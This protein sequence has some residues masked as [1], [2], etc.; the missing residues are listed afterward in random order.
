MTKEQEQICLAM[1]LL[2]WEK[3]LLNIVP[4][5]DQ[6][7]HGLLGQWLTLILGVF[8]LQEGRAAGRAEGSAGPFS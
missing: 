8:F 1:L 3:N 7:C 5:R 4:N 2:L 6:F